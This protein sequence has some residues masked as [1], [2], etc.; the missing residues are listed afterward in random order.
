MTKQRLRLPYT[1]GNKDEHETSG[2]NSYI[3]ILLIV[4]MILGVDMSTHQTVNFK[5]V[6][7][8]MSI[9]TSIM[10]LKKQN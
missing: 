6:I 10:L 7:Y 8:Y 9:I 4:M 5:R 1:T 3:F 2:R